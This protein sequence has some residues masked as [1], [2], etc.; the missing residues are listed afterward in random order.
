MKLSD[1]DLKLLVLLLLVAVIV[2]PIFFLIRP[3]N[4]KIESTNQHIGQL[5]EREDFLA[6]LD[7]NREFYNNSIALL[8]EERAKIISNYADGVRDENTVMFLANTEKQIPIAMTNLSFS[9]SEPTIITEASVDPDGNVIDGLSAVTSYSTVSFV[10]SYDSLKEFLAFIMGNKNKMVIS[11]LSADQNDE[12]G[13]ITGVFVLNQYAVSGE[14]RELEPAKI[15]SM[16]HGVDNMFGVPSGLA[17]ELI[18]EEA[19][20]E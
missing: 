14:G 2:C 16:D 3:F 6:K 7:A 12:N 10:A 15:P 17:Q 18:V 8:A 13:V 11:S 19:P 1:R 20:E 9:Q 4:E 5:R